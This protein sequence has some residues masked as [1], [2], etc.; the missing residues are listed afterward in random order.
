M[1]GGA[2]I[3]EENVR[4]QTAFQAYAGQYIGTKLPPDQAERL[5]R[6]VAA[7]SVGTGAQQGER[8]GGRGPIARH[9]RGQGEAG[10]LG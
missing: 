10:G 1:A 9:D 2:G 3:S 5:Q 4:F 7:Y 8:A 6:Q